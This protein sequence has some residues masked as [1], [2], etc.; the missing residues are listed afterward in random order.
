MSTS[1]SFEK[2]EP[3]FIGGI[4]CKPSFKADIVTCHLVVPVVEFGASPIV[5]GEDENGEIDNVV[6]FYAQAND[7]DSFN[8]VVEF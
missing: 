6:E 7:D 2:S 3:T 5:P 4:F 8:N 1:I